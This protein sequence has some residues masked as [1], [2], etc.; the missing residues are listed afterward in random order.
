MRWI[1]STES[2]DER[3]V[4]DDFQPPTIS[5]T[6]SMIQCRYEITKDLIPLAR[7]HASPALNDYSSFMRSLR[8]VTILDTALPEPSSPVLPSCDSSLQGEHSCYIWTKILIVV[9]VQTVPYCIY[10]T[11][12]S[13]KTPLSKVEMI[14]DMILSKSL[15]PSQMDKAAECSKRSVVKIRNNFRL[16]GNVKAPPTHVGSNCSIST[17]RPR[18]KGQ[19]C[20]TTHR[21]AFRKLV[22]YLYTSLFYSRHSCS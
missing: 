5:S 7:S 13:P 6:D 18:P 3:V 2:T 22:L 17:I 16:F 14:Q 11:R 15:A 9:V 10:V 21:K 4:P 20:Y 8:S 12:E 19:H 1:D